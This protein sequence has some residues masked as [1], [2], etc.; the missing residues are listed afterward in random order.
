MKLDKYSSTIN[1]I[2]NLRK[3]NNVNWMDILRIAIKYAPVETKK[4]L[5]KIN[6]FD[7]KISKELNNLIDKQI[8]M[9]FRLRRANKFD[10]FL[11]YNWANDKLVIKNSLKRKK[12]N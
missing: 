9:S 1:K 6:R 3:K 8:L 11:T 4:L 7:K 12:K 10:L 2:E 5:N